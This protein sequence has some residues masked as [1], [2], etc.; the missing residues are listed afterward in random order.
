MN[1]K[2]VITRSVIIIIIAWILLYFIG[3]YFGLY[4]VMCKMGSNCPTQFDIYLSYSW[5]TIPV[6]FLIILGVSYLI[7]YLKKK[8]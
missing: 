1:H 8:K 3:G 4:L 5:F 6:L 2:K 7:E